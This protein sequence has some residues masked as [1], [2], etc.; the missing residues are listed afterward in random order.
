MGERRA[1]CVNQ[2]GVVWVRFGCLQVHAGK[3]ST[4]SAMQLVTMA[5]IARIDLLSIPEYM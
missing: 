2:A 5:D 3:L 4:A 1:V